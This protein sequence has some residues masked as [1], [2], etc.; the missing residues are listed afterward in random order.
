[1]SLQVPVNEQVCGCKGL[2]PLHCTA[3][4]EQTPEQAPLTQ[5]W[6]T[7]ATGPPQLP[8]VS[9]VCTPLPAHWTTPGL[10]TPVQAPL[11]QA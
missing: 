11:T 5:A 7:Q 3:P 2:V 10:H 1:M 8:E 4:G 9:Q 6:F